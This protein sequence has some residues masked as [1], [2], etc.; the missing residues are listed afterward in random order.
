MSEGWLCEVKPGAPCPAQGRQQGAVGSGH[1]A[2]RQCAG[3]LIPTHWLSQHQE[4]GEVSS[5]YCCH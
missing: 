5:D 2:A 3:V 4:L 1:S